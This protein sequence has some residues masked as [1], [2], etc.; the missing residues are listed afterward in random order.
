MQLSM[1]NHSFKKK[2]WAKQLL[3]ARDVTAAMLVLKNE[4]I[5]LLW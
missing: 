1:I 4:S 2:T 3:F 5:S